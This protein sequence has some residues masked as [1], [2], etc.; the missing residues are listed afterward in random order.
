ME[1]IRLD[2]IM[3]DNLEDDQLDQP[4]AKTSTEDLLS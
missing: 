1:D 4:D 3:A 2:Q